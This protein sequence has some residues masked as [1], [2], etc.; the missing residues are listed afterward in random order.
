[1]RVSA[2]L[3]FFP[4]TFHFKSLVTTKK[5]NEMCSYTAVQIL[6]RRR[7][8]AYCQIEAGP[9]SAVTLYSQERVLQRTRKMVASC[10]F[11]HS[12]L[13]TLNVHNDGF[14]WLGIAFEYDPWNKLRHSLYWS[15]SSATEDWPVG[16]NGEEEAPPDPNAPFDY[17][18]VPNKFYFTVEGTGV[19]EPKDVVVS[20]LK[21]LIGKLGL[22]QMGLRSIKDANG[23]VW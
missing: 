20:G 12:F 19:L 1:M 5:N 11:A 10:R 21:M 16:P 13:Y 7:R 17:T 4:F 18:A 23:G 8:R 14:F 6:R 2:V 3:S 22:V 15:E 9:R